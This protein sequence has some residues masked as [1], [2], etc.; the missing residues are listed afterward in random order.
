MPPRLQLFDHQTRQPAPLDCWQSAAERAL[1]LCL[2]AATSPASELHALE[3]LEINLVDDATIAAVHGEFLDDPAPTDVIT[4]PH[5]EVFISLDMAQ[6]QAVENGE[7]Y[8]REVALYLVHA[9]LHLAGWDDREAAARR[10]MH[11]T[12]T[13][14]LDRVWPK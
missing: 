2:A 9:L 14:I 10:E 13:A 6:R 3:E 1:P 8:E 11:R 4:F 12:Q 5:G 7:S